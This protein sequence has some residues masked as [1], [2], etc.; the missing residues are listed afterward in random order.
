MELTGDNLDAVLEVDPRDVEAEGVTGEERDVAE[1]V[2][3]YGEW[4]INEYQ[5]NKGR[6]SIG[7]V[8]EGYDK[9]MG[10][11]CG[12]GGRVKMEDIQLSAAVIQ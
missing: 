12:G 4:R 8:A 5:S 10:S 2:A 9:V 1:E 3:P 11:R 6:R 7:C